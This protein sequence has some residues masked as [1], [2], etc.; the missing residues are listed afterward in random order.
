MLI[1]SATQTRQQQ[2]IQVYVKSQRLVTL[3]LLT[4]FSMDSLEKKT[5]KVSRGFT[6]TYYTSPAR[7]SL[8]SIILFH[9][10][11]DAAE[12][13][14]GV[15]TNYLK[16]AGYGIVALDCLGYAG[17]SKPTD[18][19]AYNFQHMS[20]DAVDILDHEKLG[21]VISLGHDWGCGIAQ[22]LY[23]F[24]PDRV[25]GLVMLNVSYLV[26]TPEP[27]DLDKTIALT[28][29]FFGYGTFVSTPPQQATSTY[30]NS[31]NTTSLH[32]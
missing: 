15:I 22:R 27:F 24:H 31:P 3:L 20:K 7:E 25:I 32:T 2:E 8:P 1:S 17:T 11:P 19:K 16:P 18:Y 4:R 28:T 23:N 14:E 9:G 26:P 12:L 29:Q 6:Y 21:N 30:H 10:W 5:F 13:W